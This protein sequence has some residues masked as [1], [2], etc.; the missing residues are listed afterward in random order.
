M[1][2]L[3]AH[4]RRPASSLDRARLLAHSQELLQPKARIE[5]EESAP[6]GAQSRIASAEGP[7]RVAQD[8]KDTV[9]QE[10]LQPK[11]VFES[12]RKN[13]RFKFQT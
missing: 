13:T 4:S 7:H 3:L 11:T 9:S 5:F 1:E 8:W 12:H 10:L 2:R 6:A